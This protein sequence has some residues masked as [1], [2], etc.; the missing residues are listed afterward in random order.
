MFDVG[1]LLTIL[2][3]I[4]GVI[5]AVVVVLWVIG[6]RVIRSDQIGIVEKW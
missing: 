5:V 6:A 4:V 3:W 1:T 2:G